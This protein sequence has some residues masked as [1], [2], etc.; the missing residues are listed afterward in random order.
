MRAICRW[1]GTEVPDETVSSEESLAAWNEDLVDLTPFQLLE[2][3]HRA[4]LIAAKDPG[5]FVWRRPDHITAEEWAAER[6][7]ICYSRLPP[8]YG[9]L[10]SNIPMRPPSAKVKAWM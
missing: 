1:P 3:I 2:E 7:K 5:K 10:V 8:E 4:L 9:A 6:V